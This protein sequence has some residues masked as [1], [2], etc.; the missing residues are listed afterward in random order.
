MESEKLVRKIVEITG[1]KERTIRYAIKKLYTKQKV[2]W[3]K[4]YPTEWTERRDVCYYLEGQEQ[5]FEKKKGIILMTI[6]VPLIDKAIEKYIKNFN[7]IPS[8]E[9]IA[10]EIET[11]PQNPEVHSIIYKRWAKR[12][13]LKKSIDTILRLLYDGSHPVEE[14][15][16]G[17]ALIEAINQ[18]IEKRMPPDEKIIEKLKNSSEIDISDIKKSLLLGLVHLCKKEY[19]DYIKKRYVLLS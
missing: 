9:E 18:S 4:R 15:L 2:T 19:A 7:K 13:K 3:F 1:I 5:L 16:K 6:S 10:I 11:D 12:T 8:I 17:T 14:G